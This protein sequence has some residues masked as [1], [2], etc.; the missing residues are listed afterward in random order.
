[1]LNSLLFGVG[2]SLVGLIGFLSAPRLFA[3]LFSISV[4]AMTTI[5][6]AAMPNHFTPFMGVGVALVCVSLVGL[7]IAGIGLSDSNEAHVVF[8]QFFVFGLVFLAVCGTGVYYSQML[9]A[10]EYAALPGEISESNWS[11]DI[12]PASEEHLRIV[13]LSLAV[14][15]A[16][17]QLG[18][19]GS[20]GSQFQVHSD[21]FTLQRV[22][23]RYIYVAPLS[24]RS[25]FTWMS[26][27]N[28]PGYVVVDALDP[29][30]PATVVTGLEFRYLNSAFF[31]NNLKRH[32]RSNGFLFTGL[33]DYSLEL[34]DENNPFFVV[35]T[36]QASLG[37]GGQIIDGVVVVNP[38]T[39]E[40]TRY[41]SADVP[42]WV[43][44]I[45]PET[46]VNKHL[47]YW[48]AL[49]DGWLNSH[50]AKTDVQEAED[51]TIVYTPSGR[52][53]F[54]TSLQ[55]TN[56]EDDSLTGVVYTDTRTGKSRLYRASGGTDSAIL[57]AV[58][59]KVSYMNWRG[60]DPVWYN[61][62]GRMTAVV[63]LLGASDTFQGV[64][65]V[66]VNSLGVATG[67]NVV[68]ALREYQKLLSQGSGAVLVG[69]KEIVALSGSVARVASEVCDGNT[70]YYLR[71]GDKNFTAGPG[72]SPILPL[73]DVGDEV[74]IKYF[75]SDEP[76]MPVT[77]IEIVLKP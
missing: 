37:W 21:D 66:N 58:A 24:H 64:A 25:F 33:E 7:F 49:K 9:N 72:A 17:K 77:S 71:V 13:P 32:L 4:V 68:V 18:E 69:A 60:E 12:Q 44:R 5:F 39:G 56:T 42:A 19:D 48:G 70:S 53:E 15:A 59:N 41:A 30:L 16:K 46:L 28:S 74:S 1:M 23:E 2:V 31:S 14:W 40:I 67:S 27:K 10:Q 11:A 3:V 26:T 6:Y 47:N 63:P 22:G 29:N 73:L 45:Y 43:D 51:T 20:L 75:S 55:S 76:V 65:L 61:L 38:T 36:Y 62:Y 34:D 52:C 57:N 50:F 54:V 8:H 35:T